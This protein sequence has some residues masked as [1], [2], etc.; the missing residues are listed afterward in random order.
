MSDPIV[1]STPTYHILKLPSTFGIQ[2]QRVSWSDN[3]LA[4]LPG[5][6]DRSSTSLGDDIDPALMIEKPWTSFGCNHLSGDSM[7]NEFSG[8]SIE[9]LWQIQKRSSEGDEPYRNRFSDLQIIYLRD[10]KRYCFLFVS[11]P[12]SVKPIFLNLHVFRNL[13][14]KQKTWRVTASISF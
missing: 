5:R 6:G 11:R 14:L 1:P 3:K 4:P 13:K 12:S 8:D 9:D 10:F 7:K 2:P